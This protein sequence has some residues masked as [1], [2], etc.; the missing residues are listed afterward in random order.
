MI[1]I[2]IVTPPLSVLTVLEL[3]KERGAKNCRHKFHQSENYVIFVMLKKLGPISKNCWN[4]YQINFQ[5]G[6]KYM[7]LGSGIRHPGSGIRKKPIPDPQYWKKYILVKLRTAVVHWYLHWYPIPLPPPPSFPHS[8]PGPKK[9][10]PVAGVCVGGVCWARDRPAR[11]WNV[12]WDSMSK[13]IWITLST[14]NLR[15]AVVAT[16]TQ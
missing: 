13:L 10:A 7:G 12:E 16:L 8:F 5:N 9:I 2:V 3:T 15:T 4:Y 14:V 6:L 11:C 1:F